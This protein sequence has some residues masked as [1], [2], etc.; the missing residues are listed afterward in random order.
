MT[1]IV[2]ALLR[3]DFG[4]K[5]WKKLVTAVLEMKVLHRM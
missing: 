2:T 5:R 4:M 1:G 3:M